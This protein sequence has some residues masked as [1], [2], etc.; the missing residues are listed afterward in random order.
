MNKSLWVLPKNLFP[1]NDGARVANMALLK[2][3]RSYFS[4]LDILYFDDKEENQLE[5]ESQINPQSLYCIPKKK[6]NSKLRKLINLGFGFLKNPNLPITTTPFC[7]NSQIEK[8]KVILAKE[9]YDIIIF[10]GLHPMSA[11]LPLID[12]KKSKIIYRAHNVEHELWSTAAKKAQWPIS[13]LLNWQGRI[14]KK[15]EL[16]CINNSSIVWTISEDDKKVFSKL[17][18]MSR[19]ETIPV[20]LNFIDFEKP[21]INESK[22]QI[23]FLGKLDWAPNKDGLQWFLSEIWPMVDKAKYQLNIVGSGDGS[24]GKQLF[25]GESINFQGFVKDIDKVYQENDF[26]IIP[27]RFGSGTRIKVVESVS[28]KL[29][30][31]STQMGILGSGLREDEFLNAETINDWIHL[32]SRLKREDGNEISK[33]AFYRLRSIFDANE[34]SKKA[35]NTFW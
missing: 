22:I 15:F 13:I 16:N 8:L 4:Q 31:I 25:L 24:W 12:P 28:K 30:L 26:S 1:V 3:M 29:P 14:M 33:K 10:D 7:E 17:A 11:F 6:I 23:L 35:Y 20:G 2:S 5:Y 21:K 27:I 32:F 19:I 34:I 9:N 18:P